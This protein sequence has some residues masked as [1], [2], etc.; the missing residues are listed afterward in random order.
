MP[1]HY[2][3]KLK[4]LFFPIC[5]LGA[6]APRYPQAVYQLLCQ[7]ELATAMWLSCC[8]APSYWVG[9]IEQYRA[10]QNELHQQW[11][12]LGKPTLAFAWMSCKKIID[13]VLP[14]I[15]AVTVYELLA[16]A[17]GLDLHNY[18]GLLEL[19]ASRPLYG[20]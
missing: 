4:Y 13:Y 8:G 7:V 9:E 2:E 1:P 3:G 17:E 6:S 18:E 14:D 10:V 12:Q 11:E 19:R 5:Q 16:A 15:R 20:Q